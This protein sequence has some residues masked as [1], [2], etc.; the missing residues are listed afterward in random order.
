MLQIIYGFHAVIARLEQHPTTMAMVW[1]KAA[2][3]DKRMQQLIDMLKHYNIKFELVDSNKLDKFCTANHQGVIAEV[4]QITLENDLDVI[5]DNLENS[6]IK[7]NFLI[8]DGITDPHN[9]GACFRAADAFG[10]HGIIAP[11][12]NSAAINGLV[13]KVASGACENIPYITVTNLGRTIKHLQ[14]RGVWIIGTSDKAEYNLYAEK[15]DLTD[16]IAW[17]MGAEGQGIRQGIIQKCDFLVSIPMQGVV[18]SLNISVAAGVCLF[19]TMR[20]RSQKIMVSI[21]S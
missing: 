9:L 19:E 13:S 3:Q 5:L 11:S 20:R 1:L 8:L 14:E 4:E 6:N 7:A 16:N 17:V 21:P 12:N 2:R 18:S 10:V 15:I